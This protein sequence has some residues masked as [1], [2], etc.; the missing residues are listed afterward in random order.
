MLYKDCG[1]SFE[2]VKF[3]DNAVHRFGCAEGDLLE[4]ESF[5]EDGKLTI[6]LYVDTPRPEDT[7]YKLRIEP[8]MMYEQ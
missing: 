3:G 8:G 7:K 5:E 1:K 6:T 4:L 2:I